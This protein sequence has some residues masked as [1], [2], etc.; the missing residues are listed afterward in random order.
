VSCH[1]GRIYVGLLVKPLPQT[2]LII[3]THHFSHTQLYSSAAEPQHFHEAA[4]H[5]FVSIRS[6]E[7]NMRHLWRA[8]KF[9]LLEV[10]RFR[11]QSWEPRGNS[12]IRFWCSLSQGGD[13]NDIK[14]KAFLRQK[15]RSFR[16]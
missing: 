2:S 8:F 14:T 6:T 5:V 1:G 15:F 4:A 13:V 7:F 12:R 3:I 9:L 16:Y 10:M 11:H